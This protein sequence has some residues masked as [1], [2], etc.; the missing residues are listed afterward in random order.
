M[1]KFIENSQGIQYGME[2]S[3]SK[4][5]SVMETDE[6]RK[7][8]RRIKKMIARLE[9]INQP[10]N[11]DVIYKAQKLISHIESLEYT[12]V[13][14]DVDPSDYEH[15]IESLPLVTSTKGK[16]YVQPTQYLLKTDEE[17]QKI[18]EKNRK[19]T[20]KSLKTVLREI[21]SI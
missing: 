5:V 13:K 12:I 1:I 8:K 14:E 2:D 4:G 18:L 3:R 21:K 19:V 17:K 10:L 11:D 16:H 6:D 15:A 20:L 7:L 9:D